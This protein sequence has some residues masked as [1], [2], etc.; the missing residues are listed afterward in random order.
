M[1]D[2]SALQEVLRALEERLLQADARQSAAELDAL[3]ADDFLEFGS[4]GRIYDKPQV[5]AALPH[6]APTTISLTDFRTRALATNVVLVT[7]Q[8]IRAG[9]ADTAVAHSL[10]SSLW[11]FMDGRWQIVFHQGTS[12]PAE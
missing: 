8:A 6:E 9:T 4:S 7:Y 3:L 2:L 5:I 10:R 12:L 1:E 11:R